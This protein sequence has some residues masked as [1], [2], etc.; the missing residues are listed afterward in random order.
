MDAPEAIDTGMTGMSRTAPP[1][2]GTMQIWPGEPY[3]L[4]ATYDGVGTNFAVHSEVADRVELCLFDAD[5]RETRLALPEVTAYTWHGYVPDVRPGQRYGF[6]VHGPFAPQSGH[7]CNPNKLLFDPYARAIDGEISYADA[8]FD[9]DPSTRGER[10]SRVDTAEFLPKSV[11]VDPYFD[12][13]NSQRPR[14][15]WHET[16]IYELHVKGFSKTNTELPPEIRGTYAGL[17][18]PAS[19]RYLKELGVTAVELM[20]VHHFLTEPFLARHDRRNYWGYNTI[21]Y[22]APHSAYSS[23]CGPG[24][25]ANEFKLMVRELHAAGLE[26]ILDVVYNHTAEGGRGGPT[27][28]LRGLDNARYYRL[29]PADRRNYVDYTGCG[30]TMNMRDPY[31]LQLLMDSLRYWVVDMHVDGFRFDLASALARELHAVDRLSAFFDLIQQDPILQTVKL[32]A[33]PWDLGEGGYQVGNFP[34]KWSEWN[35]RFRDSVRDFWRGQDQSLGEFA[36]RLT[37]SSDLYQGNGRSPHASINFVTAHDGFTLR[38]LVSYN[39][40]HNLDN[41][42]GNRDGESHNRSWNC[43]V[44]GETKDRAILAL[45]AR[46]QRNFLTTLLLSQGVPMLTMGD[47]VGRTQRGNNNAYCQDN[48]LSWFDWQNSDQTLLEFTKAVIRLRQ[49]HP[50]FR[51]PQF[52][53]GESIRGSDLTDIGWFR[54]DGA[55]MTDADWKAHFA[56]AIAVFLNGH[57]LRLRDK[58]GERYQDD[59]FLLLFN[60]HND[61]LRFKIPPS[62]NEQFWHDLLSTNQDSPPLAKADVFHAGQWVSVMGHSIRLLCR[63]ERPDTA[64]TLPTGPSKRRFKLY[65]YAR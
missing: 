39:G 16:I 7:L 30:N 8:L 55:E 50:I 58:R 56:K 60:A 12:W 5:G 41:G 24:Q 45:R 11:V 51:S 9:F 15:P 31:V 38:D 35:A 23:R 44:E 14:T 57:G 46:Q 53:H 29:S 59:S 25:Q 65:K 4:G 17:A 33:E 61:E 36:F 2:S 21:G 28:C 49:Q 62:L 20:P 42:E 10:M 37:G 47:E 1:V 3:P 13:R 19:I 54:P 22:F 40:K 52:F 43:G 34:P 27:L 63:R 32:I 64:T 48:E 6:R 26:V 18:H